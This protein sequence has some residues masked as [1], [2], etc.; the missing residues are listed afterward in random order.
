[1]T[2]EIVRELVEDSGFYRLEKNE[3]GNFKFIEN[4]SFLAGM[5]HPGGGRNDIPNRLKQHFFIFNM[6][7]SSKIGVIFDPILKNIF[8][9]K[10]FDDKVNSVI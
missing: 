3:R 5:N 8:K 7:L 1:M 2:L 10:F 6:T 4:L 9:S